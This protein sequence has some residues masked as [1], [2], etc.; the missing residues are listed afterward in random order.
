LAGAPRE[1]KLHHL[2]GV[3][4]CRPR[5]RRGR[6]LAPLR[7]LWQHPPCFHTTG[8]A[9]TLADVVAHYN[10]VRKLVLTTEQQRGVIKY[11]K[12]L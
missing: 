3:R 8:S 5:Q 1:E 11:L 9:A 10:R 12:S 4:A 6:E 2:R 7:A